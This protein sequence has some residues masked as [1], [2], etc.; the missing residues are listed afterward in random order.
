MNFISSS[1][2]LLLEK[3]SGSA[4]FLGVGAVALSARNLPFVQSALSSGS[5]LLGKVGCLGVRIVCSIPGHTVWA[6]GHVSALLTKASAL[7]VSTLHLQGSFAIGATGVAVHLCAAAAAFLILRTAR[8]I[9]I[10]LENDLDIFIKDKQCS[11]GSS[12]AFLLV[13]KFTKYVLLWPAILIVGAI[14]TTL[15]ISLYFLAKIMCTTKSY[16]INQLEAE[17]GKSHNENEE[18]ERQNQ[19]LKIEYGKKLEKLSSKNKLYS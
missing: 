9:L 17:I 16:S 6:W 2:H 1:P 14:P 8:N 3:I 15:E 4:V 19:T 7:V 10:T 18:L 11:R 12:S 5:A 13:L